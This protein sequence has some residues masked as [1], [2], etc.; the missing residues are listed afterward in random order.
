ME[1]KL[2]IAIGIW[3]VALGV[4]SFVLFFANLGDIGSSRYPPIHLPLVFAVG[5]VVT[6]FGIWLI[7]KGFP[8]SPTVNDEE[9]DGPPNPRGI[10]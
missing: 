7:R 3:V 2:S 4:Y 1:S 8:P 10:E 9:R 6:L 5:L